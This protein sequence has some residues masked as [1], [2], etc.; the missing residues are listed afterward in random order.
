VPNAGQSTSASGLFILYTNDV[1]GATIAA[2]GMAPKKVLLGAVDESGSGGPPAPST[3][4]LV[5]T[6]Q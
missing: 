2:P 3:F 6:A 5:M 1:V 4:S